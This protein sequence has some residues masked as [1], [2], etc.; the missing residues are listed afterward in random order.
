[1]HA[2]QPLTRHLRSALRLGAIVLLLPPATASATEQARR[3][4]EAAARDTSARRVTLDEAIRIAFRNNPSLEQ[5]RAEVDVARSDRLSSL[6]EFLPDVNLGY[7]YTNA[8]T[9][10]LDPTGQA[11]TRTAYTLQLGASYDLFT[12]LRRINDLRSSRLQVDANRASLRERRYEVTRRVQRTYFDAVAARELAKVEEDRV[13]RQENQLEFVRQQAELGRATRSDVLGSRVDLNEARLAVLNAENDAR[14]ATF[15]LAEVLGLRRRVAPVRTATLEVDTLRHDRDEL[16]RMAVDSGPRAQAARA[17]LEVARSRAEASKSS[18]LPTLTFRGGWAWQNAEF[19]PENRS[20]SV[21]LQGSLPLF[22][23]FDR[24]ASAFRAEARVHA[25]RAELTAA[26]L[27]LRAE[28]DD[29][30]SQLKSATAGRELAR[31][32]VELSRE[33]L[34]VARERFELGLASILE[35]QAAQIDLQQAQ[36]ELVRRRFDHRVGIARLE[37]LVGRDLSGEGATPP[38]VSDA[39]SSRGDPGSTSGIQ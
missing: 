32:N 18:Y 20:W 4:A 1:M 38:A 2:D 37:A 21:G 10:R 28:V 16:I 30:Y 14:A 36:V 3:G 27:A 26:Q 31:Q 35:L 17:S 13:R 24:E 15:R 29:A 33:R 8:S 11:I 6:G 7:G 39:S 22:N 25:A 23:G 34:T 12:G 19:P 5:A 9:G